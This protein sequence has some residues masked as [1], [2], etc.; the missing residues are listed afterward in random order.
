MKQVLSWMEQICSVFWGTLMRFPLRAQSNLVV[1]REKLISRFVCNLAQSLFRGFCLLVVRVCG[2]SL[3]EIESGLLNVFK[4][5]QVEHAE[6]VHGFNIF[7]IDF[8]N[9][10]MFV[11]PLHAVQS[12]CTRWPG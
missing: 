6:V 11:L 5:L 2:Q 1:M 10:L 12:Y 3:T 4:V 9:A 7:W 8:Q